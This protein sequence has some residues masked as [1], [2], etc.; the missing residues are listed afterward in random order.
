MA[1]TPTSISKRYKLLNSGNLDW[2]WG[3]W[4]S[5]AQANTALPSALDADGVNVRQGK[6]VAI[7]NSVGGY[8]VHWW[9]NNYTDSGL[10]PY[11]PANASN[12][13]IVDSYEDIETHPAWGGVSDFTFYVVT[14]NENMGG[15][16]GAYK[17]VPNFTD[18]PAQIAI[19]FND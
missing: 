10:V 6:F 8:V 2:W 15:K 3:P 5:I 7:G 19:D 18:T 13:D 11:N 4:A 9:N 16:K 1:I 12:Y 17:Y 14:D